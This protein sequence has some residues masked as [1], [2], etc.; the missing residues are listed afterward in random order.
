M[1]EFVLWQ[2]FEAAFVFIAALALF[3][4]IDGGLAWW[5]ALPLFFA[6]DLSFAFY[7]LGTKAGALVYNL[8]HTYALGLVLLVLGLGL[9]LPVLGGLG[10]LWLG[11]AGFDRMLGYGLKSSRS[12]SLTHLGQIGK[13]A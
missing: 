13:K 10:A 6:P 12:F 8:V 11:H 1:K 4:Q 9:S 7:G 2:R 5:M 3:W